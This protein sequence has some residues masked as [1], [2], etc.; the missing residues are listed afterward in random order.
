[1]DNNRIKNSSKYGKYLVLF[2]FNLPLLTAA[3]YALNSVH[4]AH[5]LMECCMGALFA[6]R[7]AKKSPITIEPTCSCSLYNALLT[8]F[9]AIGFCAFSFHSCQIPATKLSSQWQWRTIISKGLINLANY[10]LE[11][12]SIQ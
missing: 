9:R 2:S 7:R 3:T 10:V 6:L 12:S 4:N 1:M 5:I 11:I 8:F